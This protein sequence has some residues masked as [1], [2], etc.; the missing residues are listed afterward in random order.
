MEVAEAGAE[1]VYA[2]ANNHYRAKAA[3]NAIQLK[4]MVREEPVPAPETLYAAYEEDLA[5][6]AYPT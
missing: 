3:V 6:W 1:E 5:G 4:S 2:V